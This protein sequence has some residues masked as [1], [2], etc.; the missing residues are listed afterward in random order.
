M[1]DA[2]GSS[3]GCN[4]ATS[5]NISLRIDKDILEDTISRKYLLSFDSYM[6]VS[7]TSCVMRVEDYVG[8]NVNFR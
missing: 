7:L 1:A 4:A 5:T 8:Q 3:A 6:F 2:G